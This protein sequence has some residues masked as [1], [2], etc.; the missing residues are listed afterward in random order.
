MPQEIEEDHDLCEEDYDFVKR[1]SSNP[2]PAESRNLTD[3]WPLPRYKK[4]LG[5]LEDLKADDLTTIKSKPK[6]ARSAVQ[7]GDPATTT[8]LAPVL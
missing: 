5:F 4:S 7:H 8:L 6:G 3:H 2:P 1:C